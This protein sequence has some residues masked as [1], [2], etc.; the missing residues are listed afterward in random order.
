LRGPPL[1]RVPRPGADA[2]NGV[3][4]SAVS[5][6]LF[7]VV[8]TNVW[9]LVAPF[10]RR[11]RHRCGGDGAALGGGV[12]GAGGSTRVDEYAWQLMNHDRPHC[13]PAARGRT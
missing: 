8:G 13:Q 10:A 11:D 1:G 4:A 12:S 7:A 9:V 6:G 5:C 3:V 2:G